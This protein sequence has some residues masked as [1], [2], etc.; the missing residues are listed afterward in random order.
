MRVAAQLPVPDRES[1]S[2]VTV[3]GSNNARQKVLEPA[4]TKPRRA[5]ATKRS[6]KRKAASRP[7]KPCDPPFRVD[8]RGIKRFKPECL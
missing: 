2:T 3:A 1:T 5:V 4:A 8:E 7:A 6:A